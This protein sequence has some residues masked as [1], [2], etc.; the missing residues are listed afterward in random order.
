MDKMLLVNQYN[1]K[2]AGKKK[3]ITLKAKGMI[4]ISLACIG[5]GGVGFSHVCNR[6]V[7]VINSGKMK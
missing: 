7:S 2:P 3:N 6:V 4:H 5:S 1:T